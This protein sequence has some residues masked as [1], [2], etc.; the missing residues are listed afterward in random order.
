MPCLQDLPHTAAVITNLQDDLTL[1]D[2][3]H[4]AL[5]GEM[6]RRQELLRPAGNFANVREYERAR[7]A[8]APLDPLPSLVIVCDEFTEMLTQKPEFAEL[9]VAIGRLGRSLSM[10]LLLASQRLEEG[11]LRGLDSHLSY[12]IGLKTFS[13]AESRA[14][15]GVAD[16]YELPSIPGSGYLKFDVSTL[17]RF[18]AA[19][20]SGAYRRDTVARGPGVGVRP[21]AAAVPQRSDR[22][23]GDA[24]RARSSRAEPVAPRPGGL[25]KSV[26]DVVVEKLQGRGMPAHEVW[27]PPLNE[28][29]SLDS[30]LPPLTAV[31][32]RGLG[33]D[34]WGGNGRLIVPI[35]IVDRP[36]EQR[37]DQLLLDFSGAAGQRRGRRRP[38]ERQEHRAARH[39]HRARAHPHPARGADLRHRPRRR[40]AGDDGRAAARRRHRVAVATPTSCGGWSPRSRPCWPSARNAS[41]PTASRRSRP[42]ASSSAPAITPTTRSVTCS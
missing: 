9:F 42:T 5:A 29:P 30:M 24:G 21:P 31:P 7:E 12:R 8:G 27:L 33:P 18:K 4:D 23:A 16:A 39:H 40:L 37:R 28:S 22:R 26:L 1:V 19:Y 20:V 10:H 25:E 3:M 6:N 11:K 15:L 14:V 35:G 38:A 34:G 36:Y 2:R 17:V 41:A 32:E 13:A